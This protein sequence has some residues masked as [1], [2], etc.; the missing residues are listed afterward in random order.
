MFGLLNAATMFFFH[1]LL[2]SN[3]PIVRLIEIKYA[4]PVKLNLIYELTHDYYNLQ[5]NM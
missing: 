5:A 2:N 1:F 3:G 4:E